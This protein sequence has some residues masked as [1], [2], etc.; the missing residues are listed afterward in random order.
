MSV[1][2]PLAGSSAAAAMPA[3][4]PASSAEIDQAIAEAIAGYPPDPKFLK[5]FTD[6]LRR[7]LAA[8]TLPT[9]AY[10]CD[11]PG[12]KKAVAAEFG[13][14]GADIASTVAASSKTAAGVAAGATSGLALA[15]TGAGIVLSVLAFIWGR[16]KAKVAQERAIL[17]EA[18]PVA[19]ET[20]VQVDA[21]VKS[22]EWSAANGG[23]ALDA[24]ASEFRKFVLPSL[25]DDGKKCNAACGY[26]RLLRANVA[27]RKRVDYPQWEAAALAKKTGLPAVA[28]PGGTRGLVSEI[29]IAAGLAWLLAA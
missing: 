23:A 28:T 15:F 9:D 12:A 2:L 24:L 5:P 8:R 22:G 21:R 11:N 7:G 18:V 6:F 27:I 13:S 16:H 4:V 17:C 1:V 26:V 29:A 25:N 3:T 14:H 19:N 20:L 10:V